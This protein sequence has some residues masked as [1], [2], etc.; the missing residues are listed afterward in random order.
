PARARARSVLVESGEP[1]PKA[2]MDA[3]STGAPPL[4]PPRPSLR[5]DACRWNAPMLSAGNVS[6]VF[7]DN[8]EAR[9]H[10]TVHFRH[11]ARYRAPGA[12]LVARG[13]ARGR[14]QEQPAARPGP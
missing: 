11:H 1:G 9:F 12:R 7:S 5:G 14:G 2:G 8:E 4:L 10:E 13:A 6:G 3:S